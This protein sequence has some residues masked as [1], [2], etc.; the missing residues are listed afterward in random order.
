MRCVGAARAAVRR[1]SPDQLRCLICR[2]EIELATSCARF[3]TLEHRFAVLDE[4][5]GQ[6]T[7]FLREVVDWLRLIKNPTERAGSQAALMAISD[8]SADQLLP[9]FLRSVEAMDIVDWRPKV[10][11]AGATSLM[12]VGRFCDA[13]IVRD[14]IGEPDQRADQL[15]EEAVHLAG[16]E[17][18]LEARELLRTLPAS[19]SPPVLLAILEAE[20]RN[21]ASRAPAELGK[22]LKLSRKRGAPLSASTNA[23]LALWLWPNAR[24]P[25]TFTTTLDRLA[26]A[27]QYD[28][29]PALRNIVTGLTRIDTPSP[30][31]LAEVMLRCWDGWLNGDEWVPNLYPVRREFAWAVASVATALVRRNRIY[32]AEQLV[33]YDK[34][35]MH[36]GPIVDAI[37][38]EATRLKHQ[39]A[40]ALFEKAVAAHDREQHVESR[41]R[42]FGAVA[43]KVPEKRVRLL[44]LAQ[45]QS[46]DDPR[47][48]AEVA[49]LLA[50][51]GR[52][53][54]AREAAMSIDHSRLGTQR[55]H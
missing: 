34:S 2:G 52:F 36:G 5:G 44:T 31:H 43:M 19:A 50:R 46:L 35:D 8:A 48:L 11:R 20:R 18:I 54:A 28:L 42:L 53:D 29:F 14:R 23:L 17:H 47:A 39:R 6:G 16:A 26:A 3:G 55:Y 30:I 37:A 21:G 51:M 40:R 4:A 7:E 49:Q 9:D 32:D 25:K 15:A 1:Y 45:E 41:T 24:A 10:L 22:L 33:A 13:R 12:K 38:L 27:D